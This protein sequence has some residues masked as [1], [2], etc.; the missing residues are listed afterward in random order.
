[1]ETVSF[2]TVKYALQR[3][4]DREQAQTDVRVCNQRLAA[5]EGERLPTFAQ[6][7]RTCFVHIDFEGLP[8]GER[9][10]PQAYLPIRACA[11]HPSSM[12][13]SMNAIQRCATA[14]AIG[15]LTAASAMAQEK[16]PDQPSGRQ[17]TEADH[18]QNMSQANTY[19]WRVPGA[20]VE[21]IATH[22]PDGTSI[23]SFKL[24]DGSLR[25]NAGMWRIEGEKFCTTMKTPADAK[26]SCIRSYHTAD[27][28][29]Q[30]WND[31]GNF[32]SY[33][34]FRK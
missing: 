34:R 26:E 2:D 12:E 29:Y 23:V 6:P 21:G 14:L 10:L 5:C 31:D 25:H 13:G 19:E 17:L 9:E 22:W 20:N 11:V 4:T 24:A 3:D 28:A 8:P 27:N 30:A 18:R 16:A 1:M 33:W 32:G 7:I 15:F